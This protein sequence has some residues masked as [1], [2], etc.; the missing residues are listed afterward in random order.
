MCVNQNCVSKIQKK[1]KLSNK[2]E[3]VKGIK[4]KNTIILINSLVNLEE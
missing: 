3:G 1:N 4:R 2:V